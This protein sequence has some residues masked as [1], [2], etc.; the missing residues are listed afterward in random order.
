MPHCDHQSETSYQVYMN[1]LTM[2]ACNLFVSFSQHAQAT[3]PSRLFKVY[4]PH[5]SSHVIKS[6]A[7]VY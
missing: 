6:S 3:H 4:T 5:P 7:M 1:V 2:T